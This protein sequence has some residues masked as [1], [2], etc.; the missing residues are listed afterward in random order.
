MGF[1]YTQA[2]KAGAPHFVGR[3]NSAINLKQLIERRPH[4]RK[5]VAMMVTSGKRANDILT[6][7]REAG[8]DGQ[9][10]AELYRGRHGEDW[11]AAIWSDDDKALRDRIAADLRL[12][13]C[14]CAI[15]WHRNPKT[16]EWSITWSFPKA[17]PISN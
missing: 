3:S 13:A 6:Q 1:G 7:L 4:L 8:A 5:K 12:G 15:I 9:Y 16:N 10:Y 14:T 2:R 17:D 11:A